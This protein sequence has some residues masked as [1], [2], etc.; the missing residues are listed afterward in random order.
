[1]NFEEKKRIEF[2]GK[3]AGFVITYLIFTTV[4]YFLLKL[5]GKFPSDW[6]Y[7]HIIFI[8]FFIILLGTV[9]RLLLK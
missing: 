8:T 3:G 1:M 6:T 2:F 9:I 7:F 5:I 4:L